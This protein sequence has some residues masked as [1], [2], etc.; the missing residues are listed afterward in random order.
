MIGIHD[1]ARGDV[2]RVGMPGD[3]RIELPAGT[4][5]ERSGFELPV[6]IV[7]VDPELRGAERMVKALVAANPDV[8]L[9]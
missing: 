9:V 4:E 3:A 5:R 2:R 1:V 8:R 6:A 7:V